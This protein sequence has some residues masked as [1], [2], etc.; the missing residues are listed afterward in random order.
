MAVHNPLFLRQGNSYQK[1][2]PEDVLVFK[3]EDNYVRMYLSKQD[4]VLL[5]YSLKSL[6]EQFTAGAFLRVHRGY[7]INV[8]ALDRWNLENN[9]LHVGPYIVPLSRSR[10]KALEKAIHLLN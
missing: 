5:F 6:E 10:R 1:I 3:A 9:E 2:R 4:S 8:K 7:I